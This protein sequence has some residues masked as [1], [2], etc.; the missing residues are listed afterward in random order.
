MQLPSEPKKMVRRL[1]TR[2]ETTNTPYNFSMEPT[3]PPSANCQSAFKFDKTTADHAQLSTTSYTFSTEAVLTANAGYSCNPEFIREEVAQLHLGTK[4]RNRERRRRMTKM[5]DVAV[6]KEVLGNA[7]NKDVMN[8][9]QEMMNFAKKNICEKF[10]MR[11][12]SC[13]H[14][15]NRYIRKPYDID[16]LLGYDKENTFEKFEDRFA[17][18]EQDIRPLSKG[19]EKGGRRRKK[20]IWISTLKDIDKIYSTS[21]LHD[22][23]NSAQIRKIS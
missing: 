1:V 12:P 11:R 13:F 22:I 7:E 6:T 15:R 10:I 5:N 9:T 8:K 20:K 23:I 16:I 3:E 19:N 21:E 4:I 14:R 2:R 17:A 18:S